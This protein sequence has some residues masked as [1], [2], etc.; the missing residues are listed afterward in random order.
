MKIYFMKVTAWVMFT[1]TTLFFTGCSKNSITI[2]MGED[3]TE[4]GQ[5][6]EGGATAGNS[7][8]KTLITFHASIESRN[9]TRSLS[10]MRK[11]VTS[12]V[13]AFKSPV[14]SLE[15]PTAQG[16]YSTATVGILTGLQDYK[17]YLPNGV[18]YFYEIS[19]NS[20]VTPPRFINGRSEPLTNGVD[21]LWASNKLQDV[22]STQVS[23]P[24]LFEHSATQVV[25]KISAGDG[26][27]LDKLVSATI[28]PALTGATM[29]MITGKITPSTSYAVPA[30]MGMNGFTAQYIMLPLKTDTPMTLTLQ[31]LADSE[32]T[33][34]TYS[35]DVPVPDGELQGGNSY[36]FSAV[37]DGNTVT[38]PNVEV[39]GWTE[40]DETGN[41]LYPSQKP[42]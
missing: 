1:C 35:V 23:M 29:D 31:I 25:F 37:I 17:M 36:V 18:Y 5:S 22:T 27:K 38:F 7:D 16:L 26:I 34:R 28:T 8:Q 14:S 12:A 4:E 19:S 24:I 13:Y 3:G 9:M 21:Y 32:N 30:N 10:P 11:G 33:P 20:S 41:P 42:D 6:D 2:N 15:T 39:L 40:V